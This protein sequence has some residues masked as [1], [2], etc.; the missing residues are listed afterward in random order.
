VG[1]QAITASDV[2]REYR[3]ELLLS[4][5]QPAGAA[6]DVKTLN[7]VRERLIDRILL[8]R[9]LAMTGIQVGRDDAAVGK[10]F[11]EV[12]SKFPNSDVWRAALASLAL[13]EDDLRSILAHQEAILRMIDQRWRPLAAVDSTEIETYYSQT[14]LP[15][16]AK[17]GEKQPPPLADVEGRIRELLV[18]KKI[19]ELLNDWLTRTRS[20]RNVHLFGSA[21][22]EAAS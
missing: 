16:L 2:L 11:D 3:L 1:S 15:E 22:L 5:S 10:R 12:R 4:G 13:S 18:Q 14:F 9:Q 17:Q 7:Q 6:P 21:G 20:E 19:D 8:D